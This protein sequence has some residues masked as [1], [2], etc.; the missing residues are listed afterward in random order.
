MGA[1]EDGAPLAA[2]K[3]AGLPALDGRLR[4]V[5]AW[6]LGYLDGEGFGFVG[7]VVGELLVEAPLDEASQPG[8]DVDVLLGSEPVESPSGLGV[9]AEPDS[10]FGGHWRML[11]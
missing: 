11:A 7:D 5:G 6:G 3:P 1:G 4:R 9:D 2:G 10:G 8:G